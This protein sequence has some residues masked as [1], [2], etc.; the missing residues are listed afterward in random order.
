[1]AE[2]I[3]VDK[4]DETEKYLTDE[5]KEIAKT[6]YYYKLLAATNVLDPADVNS[7]LRQAEKAIKKSALTSKQMTKYE[8]I[9]KELG[10]VSK[11]QRKMIKD[12]KSLKSI[13]KESK[14]KQKSSDV[15]WESSDVKWESV[16]H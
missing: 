12:G 11:E 2:G 10:K 14:R 7:M 15:K 4:R 3:Y 9:E 8:E 5:D 13:L 16:E 1:M 6:F